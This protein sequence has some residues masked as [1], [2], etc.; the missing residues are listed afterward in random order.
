M[1]TKKTTEGNM[2]IAQSGG[3]TAVINQSLIGAVMEAKK[4]AAIKDIY[5][6]L[7]GIQGILDENLINLKSDKACAD[8]HYQKRH[9]AFVFFVIRNS[10]HETAKMNVRICF[11]FIE[12]FLRYIIG[13]ELFGRNPDNTL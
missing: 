8:I 3:P 9:T 12:Y 5:G 7:H 1:A 2:L 13:W 4:H 11:F 6:A 10:A